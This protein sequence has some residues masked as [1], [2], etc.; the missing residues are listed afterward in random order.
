MDQSYTASFF[1]VIK[2][3]AA[4]AQQAFSINVPAGTE[5]WALLMVSTFS[6]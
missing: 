3:D 5:S 1:I 4:Q 2:L 6:G